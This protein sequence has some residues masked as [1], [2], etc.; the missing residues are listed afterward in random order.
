M[1]PQINE[2]GVL[3]AAIIA[4]AGCGVFSSLADGI[5]AM[6]KLARTFEP[7]DKRRTQYDERFAKYQQLWPLLKEYLRE[8]IV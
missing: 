2:A 8:H 6:V 1:Q 5:E 3:G 7:N 4:G